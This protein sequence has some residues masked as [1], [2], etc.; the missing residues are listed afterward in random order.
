V[1]VVD[2]S[3]W[4]LVVVRVRFAPSGEPSELNGVKRLLW[5]TEPCALAVV[6]PGSG[7]QAL[8]LQE[9]AMQW[10]R[11]YELAITGHCRAIAWVVENDLLRTTI[12]A[13]L[14]LQGNH[15]FGCPSRTVSTLSP[16]MEWL[17]DE[18]GLPAAFPRVAHD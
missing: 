15:A 2:D 6:V 3:T 5:A 18:L 12:A 7:E 13:L 16:A 9:A 14:R 11:R 8:I 4:P 10:F 1:I 17:R